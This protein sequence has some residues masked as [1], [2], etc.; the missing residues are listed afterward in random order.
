[1]TMMGDLVLTAAGAGPVL[2]ELR[3]TMG[4]RIHNTSS[5]TP[6]IILLH[7]LPGQRAQVATRLI[8]SDKTGTP[9]LSRR[10]PCSDKSTQPPVSQPG[11]SGQAR[12]LRPS[13]FRSGSG[14]VT[15]GVRT[16]TPACLRSPSTSNVSPTRAVATGDL[17][18]RL[19]RS[20][21]C[22]TH[23]PRTDHATPCTAMIR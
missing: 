9:T 14:T 7:I 15:M 18:A 12:A 5:R 8:G 16:M 23:S 6:E 21:V 22:W 1:V 3:I 2:A 11:T 4:E 17:G 10:H 13:G 19:Q 20:P